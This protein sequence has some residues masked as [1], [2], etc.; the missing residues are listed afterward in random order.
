MCASKVT[1]KQSESLLVYFES[2]KIEKKYCEC[3]AQYVKTLDVKP[4]MAGDLIAKQ[5]ME[6]VY[7]TLPS[8]GNL[9]VIIWGTTKSGFYVILVFDFWIGL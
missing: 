4:L 9:L 6:G 7:K 1:T 5:T 2:R 3:G 8:H